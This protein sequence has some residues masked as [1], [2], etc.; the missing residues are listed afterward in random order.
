MPLLN[1]LWST[2]AGKAISLNGNGYVKLNTSFAPVL[3]AMD[4]T[5]ELWFK[6]DAAQANTTL[7][8]AMEVVMEQSLA[9]HLTYLTLALKADCSPSE[10]MALKYCRW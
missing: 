1:G 10:T 2:P 4:Y 5:M 3:P 6:G 9:V 7:A 8:S